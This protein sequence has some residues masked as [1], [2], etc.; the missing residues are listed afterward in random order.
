MQVNHWLIKKMIDRAL[1]FPTPKKQLPEKIFA[2]DLEH[3]GGPYMRGYE[4]LLKMEGEET[5]YITYREQ[6]AKGYSCRQTKE[7]NLI[8]WLTE[9]VPENCTEEKASFVFAG[10]LGWVEEPDRGG[11]DFW[12]NGKK[13]LKFDLAFDPTTWKSKD[14]DV[15]LRYVP[16]R[17]EGSGNGAGFFYV[18]VG[19]TLF[20]PAESLRFGVTSRGSGTS[21]LHLDAQI[22]FYSDRRDP[23]PESV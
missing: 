1:T 11:F 9:P 16:K 23:I 15:E 5:V 6:R 10:G 13:V 22:I 19:R 20:E 18:K 4:K 17:F 3:P 21:S 2:S 8:E 7:G 12:I 14:G